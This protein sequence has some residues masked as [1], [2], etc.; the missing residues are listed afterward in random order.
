[1]TNI[2]NEIREKYEPLEQDVIWLHV[3]W[4]FYR[5]LFGTDEKRIELLN[6]IAPVFFRACQDTMID[7]LIISLDRLT[8]P[9]K[10][11]NCDTASSLSEN[12][13]LLQPK[14]KTEGLLAGDLEKWCANRCVSW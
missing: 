7:D 2:P 11:G 3:K 10:T 1:M 9:L 14:P 6:E 5:Q 12:I 13:V 4:Q 8:D